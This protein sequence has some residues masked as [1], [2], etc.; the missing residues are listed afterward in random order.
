[1]TFPLFRALIDAFLGKVP[2][3]TSSASMTPVQRLN[4]SRWRRL[5]TLFDELG[6]QADLR[7]GA[8]QSRPELDCDDPDPDFWQRACDAWQEKGGTI[9]LHGFQHVLR[10]YHGPQYLPF[11]RRSEFAGFPLDIKAGE[12]QP[13]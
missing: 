6:C 8:R 4:R 12:I 10:A 1:V 7:G 13:A 5:E 2:R 11:Y 3:A 9:G